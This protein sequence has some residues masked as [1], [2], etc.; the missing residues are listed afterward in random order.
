[1]RCNYLV[2]KQLGALW[3]CS[4]PRRGLAS[5]KSSITLVL[6]IERGFGSGIASVFPAALMRAV[7]DSP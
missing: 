5:Y 4:L 6:R 1:M 2:I 3:L 7:M